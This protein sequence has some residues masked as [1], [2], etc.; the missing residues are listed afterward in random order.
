[1]EEKGV[2]EEHRWCCWR[3]AGLCVCVCVSSCSVLGSDTVMCS[4]SLPG[5]FIQSSALLRAQSQSEPLPGRTSILLLGRLE[6]RGAAHRDS[7]EKCCC[8]CCCCWQ[9]KLYQNGLLSHY[10]FSSPHFLK[11]LLVLKLGAAF[12]ITSTVKTMRLKRFFL[13]KLNNSMRLLIFTQHCVV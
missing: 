13:F 7:G 12:F 5:E 11:L 8:C 6:I 1:M 3:P 10:F 4:V 9:L 2:H